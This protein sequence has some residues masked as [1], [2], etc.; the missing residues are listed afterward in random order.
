MLKENIPGLEL[1]NVGKKLTLF[2]NSTADILISDS[3]KDSNDFYQSMLDTALP[4]RQMMTET[5]NNFD[6]TFKNIDQ[7]ISIP[8]HLLT[9]VSML[10]DGPGVSN[11][12]FSQPA[13]TITQ[14]I[15]FYWGFL[16]Q[17][18]MNHRTAGEGGGHFFNSSLPLPLASQ[19][20]ISQVITAESSPLHIGSSQT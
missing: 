17:P 20:D 14:L 12:H 2:F 15:F 7:I 6:E 3:V 11:R 8:I 16:S 18:F 4:L 5:S 13:L 9:L 19:A 1:C 10:I